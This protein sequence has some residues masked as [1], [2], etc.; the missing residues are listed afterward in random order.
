[1]PAL[2]PWIDAIG[3]TL[4]HFVWQGLFI[5][6]LYAAVRALVP[7]RAS[8]V[9]YA[10]G[11]VALALLALA[12]LLTLAM[13]WPSADAL[14]GDAAI[15]SAIAADGAVDAGT[16][17]GRLGAALP[18]LV[19]AWIA[20]VCLFAVRALLQWRCLDRIVRHWA[21][22]QAQVDA[23]LA[24]IMARFDF[25]HRV[26]ALVSER[27]DT[28]M[29]VGWIKPVILLPASVVLGFPRQ[30]IELILAHELG[31]LRR[32]DHLV[33]LLQTVVETVLFYHP[34]VHWISREVRNERE[35]CCDHLVLR[36]MRGEPSEYA[37]TLAALEELRMEAPLALAASGGE[38]LERVR[39]IV[40]V[41]A[42]HG[43]VE[44]RSSGRW[45][46]LA[47]GLLL[48]WSLAQRIDHT[49][50]DVLM[51]AAPELDAVRVQAPTMPS[52]TA[53]IAP[54]TLARWH[55]PNLATVPVRDAVPAAAAPSAA[56][57]T[58]VDAQVAQ[59]V[60]PVPAVVRTAATD[61]A[62]ASPREMAVAEIPAVA[63][64]AASSGRVSEVLSAT[65]A[66]PARPVAIR[67]VAP[68]FPDHA[69]RERAV[70]EASFT[71]AANG[72]V[73][74]IRFA[75]RGEGAFRSEAERALRQWRFDPASLPANHGLR[76]SQTFVFAPP[77]EAAGDEDGSICTR[78]VRSGT[79]LPSV[80]CRT[81]ADAER[82]QRAAQDWLQKNRP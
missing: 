43:A 42:P 60:A 26:R 81:A 72:S 36:T 77:S 22:P 2:A 37:R 52:I 71:I 30:Q 47:S 32:G 50:I 45:L 78:E 53:M 27:I 15:A 68:Q 69:R 7:Q 59:A 20:G 9:R 25:R 12:P 19:A 46:M 39:R 48:A 54:P 80:V 64:P 11:L 74:D 62:L 58:V 38:L 34:V 13:L 23:M 65:P 3:W 29:L 5:G 57:A 66:A 6:V 4:L 61:S 56:A 82:N 49:E 40:G 79:H 41:A 76:Y 18:W 55:V 35:L 14:P 1:M 75:G 70:V 10:V 67:S 16:W 21:Q 31:H 17:A 63:T 33:N 51:P 24:A 44:G 8:E 28:P 73:R